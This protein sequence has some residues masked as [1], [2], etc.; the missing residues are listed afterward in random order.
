M[1]NP[2]SNPI[3]PCLVD[4]DSPEIYNNAGK[5]NEGRDKNLPEWAG[6]QPAERADWVRGAIS[7][8]VVAILGRTVG[9][10]EPLMSAGLDSLGAHLS[11]TC[12]TQRLGLNISTVI[13][14]DPGWRGRV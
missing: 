11:G 4:A 5:E 3:C 6:M 2:V 12:H 13:S 8:A 10:E 1:T 9:P 7:Q 14:I